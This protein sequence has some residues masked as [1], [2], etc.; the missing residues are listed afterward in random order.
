MCLDSNDRGGYILSWNQG[1]T[2]VQVPLD[3]D[4][5]LPMIR[6]CSTYATYATF[7]AAFQC[8]P[9]IIPD[10]YYDD[11][12]YHQE[13]NFQGST[14]TN[15]KQVTFADKINTREPQVHIDDPVTHPD[16][17]LFL[18]WHVKL[19]HAPFRNTCWAV[20]LGIL[21]SKLEECCNVVCPAC[22][23][24]KQKRR[25]W[26]AKGAA[27]LQHHIKKATFPGE[28]VSVDQLMSGTPGLVGQT[29][30]RLTTARYKVAMIFVDHHSD[31]DYVHVQESASAVDTIEVKKR[32]EQFCHEHGVRVKHYHADNGIF[33][34][35]GFRDEVQRCGQTLSFCGVGAHHQNGVA[36][37][38]IQDL[39]DLARSSLAH[40]A[41]RNPARTA[42][43]WPYA[44]RYA[45]YVRRIMP[46]E[47]HSKPP[48]EF[49]AKSKVRPT[50]KYL[51]PFGCPVYVLQGPR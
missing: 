27:G 44:L 16:E 33:A 36:K 47:N 50:T 18:S 6:G 4:V 13:E 12:A 23:Y 41:H 45:S 1:K 51:H 2:I 29:T 48:E 25:P 35:K 42:N 38:R 40:A 8:H 11:N 20:K 32:F 10:N 5:N 19:G 49:F 3:H 17:A 14:A 15:E 37:R 34:S 46:R 31:L 39:A 26:R 21:P 24:G 7:A 30:G 9:A 28:C 22:L 43:L